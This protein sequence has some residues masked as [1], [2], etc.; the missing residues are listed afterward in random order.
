MWW[1]ISHG[2]GDG[3]VSAAL[4]YKILGCDENHVFFSHPAGLD[5]DIKIVKPGDSVFISD[6]ALNEQHTQSIINQ[7]ENIIKNN[8]NVIYIDHHPEPLSIKIKDVPGEVYHNINASAS[9]LTYK[10]FQNKLD[11]N[12][13]RVAL[14]GAIS[15]YLDETQWVKEELFNWDKRMI[16]FEAGILA[17]GLERSRRLYD[18]KR[19]IVVHLSENKL[20]SCNKDLVERA[21][22]ESAEEEMLRIKITKSAISYEKIAYVIDPGG[23]IARA[24][25][26]VRAILNKPI[27]IAIE[28]KDNLAIMSIRSILK[29]FDLNTTLR[30]ICIE[31]GGSGG[32]HAQAAG[33]RI[34]WN[35]LYEFFERLN[36]EINS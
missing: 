21:L 20:P 35:K 19:K 3:V 33:A 34:P 12:M 26:Y 14:Y 8:G 25:T 2:D 27:G 22:Q 15:D 7:L 31:L 32:G 10:F 5:E 18:F 9:E 36:K 11:N 28:R 16:Y 24:A 13:K 4:A 6:I 29:D 23:S 1:I 30:E 17:Q